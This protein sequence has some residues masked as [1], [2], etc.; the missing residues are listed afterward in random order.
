MARLQKPQ[1]PKVVK[2]PAAAVKVVPKV[3]A[4]WDWRGVSPKQVR[5]IIGPGTTDAQIIKAS[6]PLLGLPEKL[7]LEKNF[8]R[9]HL[10]Y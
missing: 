5:D 9:L 4:A 3:A 1:K 6:K 2:I 10:R 8:V 7:N